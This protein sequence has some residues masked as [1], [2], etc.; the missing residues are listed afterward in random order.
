MSRCLQNYASVRSVWRQ[1]LNRLWFASSIILLMVSKWP[2]QAK[3]ASQLIR[4]GTQYLASQTIQRIA[5][6]PI[7]ELQKTAPSSM[8]STQVLNPSKHTNPSE[9]RSKFHLCKNIIVLSLKCL[10][11]KIVNALG[12]SPL[13]HKEKIKQ[14]KQHTHQHG[15]IFC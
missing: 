2:R 4:E 3:S 5:N 15:Q 12:E 11:Y 7:L 6:K 10:D 8:T 13:I 1:R 14:I 9:D